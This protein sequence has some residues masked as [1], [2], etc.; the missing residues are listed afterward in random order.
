M[1]DMRLS[2]II[3]KLILDNNIFLKN[4]IFQFYIRF[5]YLT[6]SRWN[7]IAW[8]R[9]VDKWQKDVIRFS[10]SQFQDF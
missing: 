8:F 3:E 4:F 9:K 2:M 7:I 6:I 5:V 10:L 1:F